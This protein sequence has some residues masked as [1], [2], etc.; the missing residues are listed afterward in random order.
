M[1][2]APQPSNGTPWGTIVSL[3]T[4]IIYGIS[5]ID[6]IP[7]VILVLGWLDD[8]IAIPLLLVFAFVFWLKYK[9]PVQK[10]A[11]SREIVDVAP[12]EP[13]IHNSY[14]EATVR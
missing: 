2:K 10:H 14:E 13:V 3:V 8:A 6:L 4:A 7:D 9:N 11:H 5:P 12:V 1:S